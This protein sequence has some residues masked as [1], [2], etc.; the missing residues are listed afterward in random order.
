MAETRYQNSARIT[1]G[2]SLDFTN[3]KQSISSSQALTSRLDRLSNYL[4]QN[5]E[6]TAKQEGAQYAVT[7]KPTLEQIKVATFNGQDASQLF[8]GG[9]TVFGDAARETQAELYRQDLEYTLSQE[10]SEM[11]S[12]IDAGFIVEDPQQ[13][14]LDMQTKIDSYGKVLSQIS[15]TQTTKFRAAATATGN[16]VYE[17]MNAKFVERINAENQMKLDNQIDTYGNV[18]LQVLND[19]NGDYIQ[20]AEAMLIDENRIN[21]FLRILPGTNNKNIN[22]FND[23]KEAAYKEGIVRY[24]MDNYSAVI[25]EGSNIVKELNKGNLGTFTGVYASLNIDAQNNVRDA[26]LKRFTNDNN[27]FAQM[28]EAVKNEHGIFIQS[29]YDKIGTGSISGQEGLS[30]IR[31]K[32]IALT[33]DQ[34]NALTS[35]SKETDDTI[36]YSAHLKMGLQGGT[37]S[38]D[39]VVSAFERRKITAKDYA[40][41]LDTYTNVTLKVTDGISRIKDGLKIP[42]NSDLSFLP[43]AQKAEFGRLVT[44]LIDQGRAAFTSGKAFNSK[45]VADEL[46]SKNKETTAA[47]VQIQNYQD[48]SSIVG[49]TINADNYQYFDT[50]EELQRLNLRKNDLKQA[51]AIINDIN[52]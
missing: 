42:E 3:V 16:K 48:L 14:A 2:V 35:P 31:D 49:K 38:K 41:L 13:F 29:I 15:P 1:D 36:A 33:I 43:E 9:G 25:P 17:K 44:E 19:T 51:I 24:M 22:A 7:N 6:Q 28:N 30:A 26:I 52:Q 12:A 11:Y 4:Y 45:E 47:K 40:S 27:T 5:L 18:L 34:R 32:G 37:F 10:F 20:A 23:A 8:V 21:E 46:L 39:D 50:V